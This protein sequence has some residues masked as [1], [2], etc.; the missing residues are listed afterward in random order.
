MTQ[1]ENLLIEELELSLK[2]EEI[3]MNG[4]KEKEVQYLQELESITNQYLKTMDNQ[5][6]NLENSLPQSLA[7]QFQLLQN[8]LNNLQIKLEILEEKA[9]I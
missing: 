6:I 9:F 8:Q 3:L 2:K 5:M 4:I 7:N 1:L